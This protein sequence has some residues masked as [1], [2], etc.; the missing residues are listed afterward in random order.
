M[1][2][3]DNEKKKIP[4]AVVTAADVVVVKRA[5]TVSAT[6]KILLY[7]M[8]TEPPKKFVTTLFEV[9]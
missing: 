9:T 6:Q 4:W 3:H 5:P 2:F 8:S 1:K 7:I